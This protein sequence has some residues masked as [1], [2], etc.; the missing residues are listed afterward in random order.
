MVAVVGIDVAKHTFDI[1]TL[2]PNGKYRTRS[3]LANDPSGFASCASGWRSTPV[4][5]PG[6]SWRL[7]A[8][9]T[10]R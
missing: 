4:P 10:R 9:T 2:Q 3:K 1:A 7:P 8:F 5:M 6:S